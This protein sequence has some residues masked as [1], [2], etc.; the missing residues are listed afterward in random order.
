MGGE[1]VV[2]G[3]DVSDWAGA[4]RMINQAVETFGDLH[5]LVNN[6]GILR[7]RVLANML[8][9][10]WDAVIKVHLKGTFAPSRWAVGLLAREGQG[11]QGGRRPHHQHHER[12]GHL[13]QPGPDELRRGEGRHRRLHDHRRAGGA[14]LRRHRELH[15]ARR[16]HPPH[17]E[18]D[19]PAPRPR[20]RRAADP[21]PRVDRPDLRVAGQPAV[22]ERDRARVPRRRRPA[23]RSP[24][25]GTW[26]PPPH[27]CSSPPT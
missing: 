17:R 7:D 19:Q 23:R 12:V 26:A 13:R 14:P 3:D 1:A 4:Q 24:R 5:V 15:L 18:P 21:R 8:E 20:R 16:A 27:R 10:E 25:A 2:N 6:A 11:G 22:E 9:E